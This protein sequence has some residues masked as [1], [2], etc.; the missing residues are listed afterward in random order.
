MHIFN[1]PQNNI[2]RQHFKTVWQK[3]ELPKNITMIVGKLSWVI[4]RA[5]LYFLPLLRE[6]TPSCITLS[7]FKPF[8]NKPWF[9]RVCSICL[10]KT[11]WAKEKFLETSNFSFSPNVYYPFENPA[12]IFFKIKIIIYK[13]FQFGKSLKFRPLGK[14]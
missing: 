11:L 1:L 14:G 12:A 8:P 7:Q 3:E 9:L 5:A 13:L 6:I 2:R 10:L 4:G